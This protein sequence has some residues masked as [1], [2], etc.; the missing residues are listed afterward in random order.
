MKR[1]FS[2]FL[3]KIF[4]KIINHVGPVG[5]FLLICLIA[6]ILYELF[7]IF[8]QKSYPKKKRRI[9]SYFVVVLFALFIIYDTVLLQKRAMM[10]SNSTNPAN[11][12]K[13]SVNIILD[14]LNVFVRFLN[15]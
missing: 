4:E 6:V 13:E 10:C 8:F 1:F 12:P 15:N 9:V 11:Y 5:I 3:D 7:Y 2:F 14:L